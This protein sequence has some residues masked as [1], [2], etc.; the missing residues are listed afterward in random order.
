MLP[1]PSPIH[2]IFQKKFFFWNTKV[3]SN[4]VFRYSETKALTE[5]CYTPLLSIKCF[6]PT[7]KFLKHRM[8]PWRSFFGAV[9]EK[10]FRK[11]REASPLFCLKLSDTRILSKPRRVLLW[12]LSALWEKD[13]SMK[14]SDI[15]FLCIE[16][17]A[18]RNFLRHRIVP[19]RFFWYCEPK[20]F[21]Q[22]VVIPHDKNQ[23]WNWCL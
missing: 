1:R 6:F 23:W 4:E 20:I 2:E 22:N 19:Q 3:F 8:V 14:F 7:R 16:F 11:N 12:S 21:E 15:P 13:F 5:N 18:T 17:F 9:R 10:S